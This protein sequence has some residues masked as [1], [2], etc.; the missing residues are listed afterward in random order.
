MFTQ[1]TLDLVED[2]FRLPCVACGSAFFEVI[3][4]GVIT[5][6]E[7]RARAHAVTKDSP[8]TLISILKYPAGKSQ[9]DG[10]FSTPLDFL[11]GQPLHCALVDFEIFIH[12]ASAEND[13][14]T[15]PAL[16]LIPADETIT[17]EGMTNPFRQPVIV[18]GD[19][20][21]REMTLVYA[22]TCCGLAKK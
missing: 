18:H 21:P 22:G 7:L 13:Q 9:E 2:K 20:G 17:W 1:P 16:V 8:S 6:A 12:V 10:T 19:S 11:G 5:R 15:Q 14:T 3:S 4:R